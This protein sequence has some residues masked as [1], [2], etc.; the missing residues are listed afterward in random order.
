M[1]TTLVSIC[2]ALAVSCPRSA[3]AETW[4]FTEGRN[5]HL[6][7]ETAD[8]LLKSQDKSH[9]LTI[10]CMNT[11]ERSVSFLVHT[12]IPVE[13]FTQHDEEQLFTVSADEG[14]RYDIR[15]RGFSGERSIVF[16]ALFDA[17]DRRFDMV[18][19]VLEARS[20]IAV[21]SQGGVRTSFSIDVFNIDLGRFNDVCRIATRP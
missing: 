4:R 1:R 20:T 7:V 21:T 5:P 16:G 9:A 18:R 2:F 15:L 12:P 6:E 17:G 8:F 19:A 3:S 11:V 13:G 10:G 14:R